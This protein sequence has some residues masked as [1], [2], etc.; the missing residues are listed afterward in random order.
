VLGGKIGRRGAHRCK[1]WYE[2]ITQA[3]P[4]LTGVD[5]TGLCRPLI[6]KRIDG[7]V[8]KIQN[9]SSLTEVELT[10]FPDSIIKLALA[11][12][13][14]LSGKIIGEPYPKLLDAVMPL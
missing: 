4:F 10:H 14:R 9:P 5:I 6:S 2:S 3:S 12:D 1:S 11:K 7:K 8:R 13:E